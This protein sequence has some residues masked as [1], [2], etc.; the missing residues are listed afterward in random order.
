MTRAK[1]KLYITAAEERKNFGRSYD[2]KVSQF[3]GEIPREFITGFSEKNATSEIT[4]HITT[5][6]SK[7]TSEIKSSSVPTAT[8]TP[9]APARVYQPKI[10]ERSKVEWQT[11]DQLKHKKWGLGTVISIDNG[12]LKINFANPEIGE[13]VLKAVAAP[14][15]KV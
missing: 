6:S 1:Q 13:K 15:E 9:T 7:R 14:V 3:V 4:H 11:G 5:A 8:S 12:Y 10:P 2:A